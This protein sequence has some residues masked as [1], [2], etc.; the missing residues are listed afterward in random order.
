MILSPVSLRDVRSY[1]IVLKMETARLC[2]FVFVAALCVDIT[3][4]VF[5]LIDLN[6]QNNE[7][8]NDGTVYLHGPC[9][10]GLIESYP[11]NLYRD[12]SNISGSVY[13]YE[14]NIRHIGRTEYVSVI[15]NIIS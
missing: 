4:M 6:L 2:L 9:D 3:P 12:R 10:D 13:C 14:D 8:F 15:V 11:V 7:T 1:L 5:N